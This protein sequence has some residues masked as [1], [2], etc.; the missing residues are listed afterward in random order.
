MNILFILILAALSNLFYFNALIS[1]A[2]I[3]KNKIYNAADDIK[4]QINRNL[5][6]FFVDPQTTSFNSKRPVWIQEINGERIYK[7]PAFIEIGGQVYFF[8]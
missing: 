7:G 4:N 8:L 2:K 3:P 1:Q 6:E 5:S